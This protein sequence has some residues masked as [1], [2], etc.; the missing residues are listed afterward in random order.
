MTRQLSVPIVGAAYPNK[1]GGNRRS[2]IAFCQIGEPIELRREPKNPHD[3]H[4]IAVFSSR[5]FQIGYVSSQRAVFLG[6]L[7]RQ[8]RQ[9]TAIFQDI[10]PW[11]AVARIGVD[12]EPELPTTEE[13]LEEDDGADLVAGFWPDED[14]PYD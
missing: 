4:A 9:L 11:G 7:L 3:E 8:G 12:C 2:E 10:A 13:C 5:G 14:P 1:D 6:T